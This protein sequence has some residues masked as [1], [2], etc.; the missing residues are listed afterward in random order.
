MAFNPTST[1]QL[2]RVDYDNSYEHVRWFVSEV[3]RTA[4]FADPERKMISFDNYTVVRTTRPDGSLQSSVK[5]A[6]GLDEL[7]SH[8]VNYMIYKNQHTT[9]HKFYAFITKMIYINEGTTELVFETDVMQT[10]RTEFIIEPS[11]IIREHTQYDEIGDNLVPESFNF[12]DYTY[13]TALTDTTLW[14]W[15][16]LIGAT[17]NILAS[18]SSNSRGYYQSGIYQGMYFYYAKDILMLNSIILELEKKGEGV[19]VFICTIPKFCLKDHTEIMGIFSDDKASDGTSLTGQ[20]LLRTSDDPATSTNTINFDSR[21]YTFDGYVPKNNK[22]FTA[23]FF[24]L[25]VTN[26]NGEQAEYN[27]EDFADRSNVEFKMYGDISANPSITLIPCDYKGIDINY[28][29]GISISSFPQCSYNS[30]TFKL[31]LAKNQYGVGL[32]ALGNV[33]QIVAG[34]GLTAGTSGAAAG[35]GVTQITSGIL[36]LM[37]T[38]NSLYTASKEPNKV[39]T[40][41]A[42]NN[43]LTAIGLNRFDYYIQTIKRNFAE[44][45]D[46]YFTKYGYA[47]NVISKPYPENRP[48]YYYVQ[49]ANVNIRGGIPNDDLNMIKS[50]YNKGVTF[51]RAGWTV[52]KY[53][54]EANK[55]A[56]KP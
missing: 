46:A 39:Q 24:K 19:I 55:A 17:E 14:E 40:G 36:G 25:V 51:W 35:I 28:D 12:Q 20:G 15:G 29:A 18:A 31:W 30:D 49:T 27:V 34:A 1:I 42:K 6:M 4:Y 9:S 3:E 13:T 16:Y 50:I 53:D 5:V 22:L 56:K 8:K 54:G 7:R 44:T 32:N 33:A 11:Y 37:N 23:P 45:V 2:C 26:H 52:G 47:R 41:S 43:L 38:A 10:W 48:C 21:A